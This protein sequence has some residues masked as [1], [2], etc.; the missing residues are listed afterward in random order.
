MSIEGITIKNLF[1]L[2]VSSKHYI[3]TFP[4]SDLEPVRRHPDFHLFAAMNPSTDVGKRD[5][6]M[7]LRNR[8]TEIRVAE[9]EPATSV[10]DREDLAFLIRTYLVAISPTAAQVSAV[11]QLYGALKRA[12]NEG[13]V[14]GVGQRPC[15]RLASLSVVSLYAAMSSIRHMLPNYLTQCYDNAFIAYILSLSFVIKLEK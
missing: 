1:Y 10:A 12:A 7:G 11:V 5:L 9:L 2:N 13:L 15:F 8:F 14:D 3:V 6:P 4:F